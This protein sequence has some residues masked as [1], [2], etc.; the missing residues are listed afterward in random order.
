MVCPAEDIALTMWV[1]LLKCYM[2]QA[3]TTAA[4]FGGLLGLYKPPQ[5]A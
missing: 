5:A 2:I 1:V 3:T 4:D